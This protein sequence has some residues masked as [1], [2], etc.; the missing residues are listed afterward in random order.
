MKRF[1]VYTLRR[2]SSRTVYAI[3]DN[4]AREPW[5]SMFTTTDRADAVMRC[6]GLN[7]I[8]AAKA[9]P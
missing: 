9:K 1:T 5:S 7:S 4:E 6:H 2:T 8:E 3:Y